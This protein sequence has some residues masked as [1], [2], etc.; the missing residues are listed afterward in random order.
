[1][2]LSDI[3]PPGKIKAQLQSHKEIGKI[4]KPTEEFI[5]CCSALLLERLIRRRCSD[6]AMTQPAN[7]SS[8]GGVVTLDTIK[9][10]AS[11]Y[12]FIHIDE[13]QDSSAPKAR[14]KKRKTTISTTKEIQEVQKVAYEAEHQPPSQQTIQ[15]IQD[16]DDYD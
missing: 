11:Q 16:D 8:S 1:M 4:P 15:V 9:A 2:D 7:D 3:F 5:E 13:L 14:R 10:A 12:D 6:D